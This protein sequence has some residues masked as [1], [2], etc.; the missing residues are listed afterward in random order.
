MTEKTAVAAPHAP[1]DADQDT[2]VSQTRIATGLHKSRFLLGFFHSAETRP[3]LQACSVPIGDIDQAALDR[4]H[5][6]AR[7]HAAQLGARSET[8][9][10]PLGS[11]PHIDA[12]R[13]EPTFAEH[14]ANA[15]S[16]D[17]AFV[18][19]GD[20]VACQPRVDWDH[21]EQLRRAAPALDDA[22]GLLR[23]CL[24]L[25]GGIPSP[26][27]APT[28]NPVTNTYSWISENP[29]VRLCGPVQGAQAESGRSLVGFSIGPGLH[30][31]NVVSVGGKH[32]LNNGYHRAVA[33]LL[34]GHTRIPVIVA[35][36]ASLAA[37]PITRIGMFSAQTVFGPVPPRVADFLG[38][39]A[40]ELPS[41]RVRLLFSVHA[42]VY[43]VP[44]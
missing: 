34:A 15:I 3:Y 12:L 38:A 27:T 22:E 21:V 25:Q 19:V 1:Q 9:V 8:I 2:R 30:Q 5:A 17:F 41:K 29:D 40:L 26:S 14:A 24:P 36:V 20:L 37:A 11:H 4:D 33:L 18:D 13:A 42:E 39:A 32:M 44:A 6:T 31:M 35:T 43:P 28:F 16:V 10:T 23:F 7:A